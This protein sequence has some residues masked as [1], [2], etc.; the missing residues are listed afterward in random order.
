MIHEGGTRTWFQDACVGDF[1]VQSDGFMPVPSE[2]GRG[3]AIDEAWLSAH[4]PQAD[5]GWAPALGSL[6][7]KQF[8]TLASP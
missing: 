8:S 7:S 2:P 1:P 3:V 4:P 6:P 5:P